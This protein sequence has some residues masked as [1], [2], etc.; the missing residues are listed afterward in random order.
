MKKLVNFLLVI[1]SFSCSNEKGFDDLVIDTK[2]EKSEIKDRVFQDEQKYSLINYDSLPLKN[3]KGNITAVIEIPAGTNHKYEYNYESK[4][5]ECEIRNGKQRVV[6]YLPYIGNYG[7]IPGTY[8]DP[9]IGGDGDAL[10]VLVLSESMNQGS[11]IDIKPVGI[12][13]LLDGGEEDH[14]VIA[15]PVIDSLNILEIHSFSELRESIKKIIQV[16]F[17]SYKGNEK[18]VFQNWEG[19]SM[20]ILEIDKWVKK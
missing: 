3:T 11:I 12:L 14:K 4:S 9:S 18:M 1:I 8:M 17:T 7:F 15:V 5:F 2:I 19:D 16:W 20:A 13:K 6:T 10:D